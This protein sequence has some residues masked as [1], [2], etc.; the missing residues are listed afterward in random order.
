MKHHNPGKNWQGILPLYVCMYMYDHI[1]YNI[2][3]FYINENILSI[4]INK[5][6]YINYT[7]I[8]YMCIILMFGQWADFSHDYTNNDK[9]EAASCPRFT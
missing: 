9:Q 8:K 1:K 5:Y 2:I 6:T 4:F 7:Y 3:Y